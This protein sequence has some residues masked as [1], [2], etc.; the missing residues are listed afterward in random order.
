MNLFM[1]LSD[2]LSVIEFLFIAITTGIISWIFYNAIDGRLRVILIWTF[3]WLSVRYLLY[4]LYVP[5]THFGVINL[6]LGW[7]RVFANLPLAII[8]TH[9]TS[10]LWGTYI[11]SDEKK[12]LIIKRK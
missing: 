12:H 11:K 7:F 1:T 4:A 3:F 10:F 6:E 2:T 9:L 5:L 8:F